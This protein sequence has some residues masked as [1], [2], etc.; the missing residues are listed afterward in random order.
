MIFVTPSSFREGWGGGVG[1]GIWISY[2]I[3]IV[4]SLLFVSELKDCV[5]MSVLVHMYRGIYLLLLFWV[6]IILCAEYEEKKNFCAQSDN[7]VFQFEFEFLWKTKAVFELLLSS[8]ITIQ[9]Y[10]RTAVAVIKKTKKHTVIME[11]P[12]ASTNLNPFVLCTSVSLTI[13]DQFASACPVSVLFVLYQRS[14]VI[15]IDL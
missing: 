10:K 15:S 12:K 1:W 11:L 7:K 9:C 8:F 2:C 14:L 6:V 4:K 5:C 13:T 3:I